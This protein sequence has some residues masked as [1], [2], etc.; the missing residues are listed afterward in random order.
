[1]NTRFGAPYFAYRYKD[2]HIVIMAKLGQAG[3]LIAL[4]KGFVDKLWITMW[5]KKVQLVGIFCLQIV[6]DFRTLVL[7]SSAA[8][9]ANGRFQT[10]S[11]SGTLRLRKEGHSSRG[12]GTERP[13]SFGS[14]LVKWRVRRGKKGIA[15]FGWLSFERTGFEE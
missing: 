7:G 12:S 6:A 4:F 14:S 8:H 3:D 13:G 10:Q 2:S 1:M 5:P 11:S 9:Q 15:I